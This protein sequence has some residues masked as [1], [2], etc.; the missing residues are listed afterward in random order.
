MGEAPGVLN[1]GS[2][3]DM[4]IVI[5]YHGM[6]HFHVSKVIMSR[7]FESLLHHPTT[8]FRHFG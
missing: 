5:I 6:M 8:L 3:F 2:W 1:G 7:F 4:R